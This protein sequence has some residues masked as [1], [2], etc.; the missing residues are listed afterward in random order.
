MSG[1]VFAGTAAL[2][3]LALRRDR[4]TLPGWLLGLAALTASFTA[5]TV[6]GFG[7]PEA[8]AEETALMAATP[9]LR[10]TGLVSGASEGNYALARGY[11]TLAVL[12]ALMS[13]FAVVRHTRQNEETGRAELVGA[14]V[15]GRYAQLA[16]GVLV[17]Q[18]SLVADEDLSR[19]TQGYFMRNGLVGMAIFLFTVLSFSL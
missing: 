14:A 6:T 17:Y 16:A 5:M 9:A 18:H 8:L 10:M 19:V 1:H 4:V 13:V 15:V 2:T 11:L 12:A 3:R 7:D